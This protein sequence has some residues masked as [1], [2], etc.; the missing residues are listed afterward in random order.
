MGADGATG[1]TGPEGKAG[2]TGP[3]GSNTLGGPVALFGNE[4]NTTSGD[5][6]SNSGNFGHASAPMCPTTAGG[7]FIFTEGG[8]VPAAG[9]SISNL[10]AEAGARVEAK[11]TQR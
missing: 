6:L 8:P 2:P 9:G 3:T 7:D 5:C 1:P 4:H 10:Q 11:R